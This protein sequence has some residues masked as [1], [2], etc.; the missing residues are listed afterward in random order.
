MRFPQISLGQIPP[1]LGGIK[2]HQA[3]HRDEIILDLD[4]DYAGDLVVNLAANFLNQKVPPIKASVSNLTL[5]SARLRLH[6]R[7]LLKG[8]L[9]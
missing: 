8:E 2:F 5:S 7:P 1:R 9:F 6:L 3:C 4:V